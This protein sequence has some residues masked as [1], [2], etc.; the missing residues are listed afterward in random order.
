M[1]AHVQSAALIIAIALIVSGAILELRGEIIEA[2]RTGA[3]ALEWTWI[4]LPV[5]FLVLLVWMTVRAD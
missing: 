3:G 2:R 1:L 4:I 5:L